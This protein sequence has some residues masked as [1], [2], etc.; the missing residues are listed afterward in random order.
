MGKPLPVYGDGLQ[1]RDWLHV[2]DHC[3]AIG[4]TLFHGEPGHVYNIGGSGETTNIEIVRALCT[5]VDQELR[6]NPDYLRQ[7]PASPVFHGRQASELITHVRDRQG[8]D[9]RYAINYSKA[10]GGLGYKPSRDLRAGLASTVQWYLRE[11]AWWHRANR[12]AES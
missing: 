1:V 5:L 3:D 4:L 12:P 2:A 9:R 8:H 6:A 10:T 11:T 7:Y